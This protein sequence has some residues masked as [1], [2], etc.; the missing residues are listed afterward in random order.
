[1]RSQRVIVLLALTAALAGCATAAR[2][3]AAG[4]VHALLISIRDNDKVAF[5]AHVDRE[6][7]KSSI[8]SRLVAEAGKATSDPNMRALSALAAPYLADA[9]NKALIQPSTFRSIAYQYGYK[10]D[11]PIPGQISIAGALKR[12]PDG[13]VCATKKKDGPCVLIFTEEGGT[14]RLSGFEGDISDL[15]TKRR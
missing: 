3:D 9:A 2:L 4:D 11:Q 8:E 10:P 5:N 6:A 12:L 14:W 13:R 15:R 7:L 1:M